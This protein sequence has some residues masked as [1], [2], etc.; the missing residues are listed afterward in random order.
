MDFA[1]IEQDDP[2]TQKLGVQSLIAWASRVD[3][4]LVPVKPALADCEAFDAA[5]APAGLRNYGER[6]WCRLECYVFLCLA[7]MAGVRLKCFGY[8]ASAAR[9]PR[10]ERDRANRRA[11]GHLSARVAE[12]GVVDDACLPTPARVELLKLLVPDVGVA[13]AADMLPSAG[14]LFDERDRAD[15]KKVEHDVSE[16]YC[17]HTIRHAC[18]VYRQGRDPKLAL[19]GKQLSDAS[20]PLSCLP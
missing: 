8:G 15:I 9:L 20:V 6:A 2:K 18:H 7:E 4:L 12:T 13:F 19:Y 3:V 14:E 16:I 11:D 1:C 10:A 5:D 17:E